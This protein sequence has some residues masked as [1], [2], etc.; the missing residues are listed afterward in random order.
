MRSKKQTGSL[1]DES[2]F[3]HLFDTKAK[4]TFGAEKNMTLN[5]TQEFLGEKTDN[6]FCSESG[7]LQKTSRNEQK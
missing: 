7:W 4:K 3:I 1:S 6:F 2:K 5:N